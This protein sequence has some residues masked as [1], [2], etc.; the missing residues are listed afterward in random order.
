MLLPFVGAQVV[1]TTIWGK[2]GPSFPVLKAQLMRFCRAMDGYSTSGRDGEIVVWA[3]WLGIGIPLL[4]VLAG[5]YQSP[6][7]LVL[8]NIVRIGPMYAHFAHVYTLS[9]MEAHRRYRL[10]KVSRKNPLG[11]AFNWWIGLFHGVLPGTFTES[12]MA[13]HHRHHN[14][15]NDVYSTAGYRRDSLWNFSRYLLVWMAYALNLSSAV[16]FHLR[17]DKKA[18]YRTGLGT[19]YYIA[20]AALSAYVFGWTFMLATVIYPLIEGNTL[21]AVVNWTWHM[22]LDEDQSNHFVNSLTIEN[23]EEFIFSEEYHVVHHATPGIDHRK[24]VVEFEKNLDKYD[25]IFENVN[26]FE[27]G[28]TAMFRNYE[29]LTNMVKKNDMPRHEVTALLKKRLLCTWW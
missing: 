1:V 15:V 24:Y 25:I 10:F 28:F 27:L 23:G 11:F 12:H 7:V 21:L 20:F 19:L 6:L 16:Y 9:H 26:L 13:N 14:D 2:L 18:L 22:F 4:W 17:Q 8:F 3:M 5:I 29:A